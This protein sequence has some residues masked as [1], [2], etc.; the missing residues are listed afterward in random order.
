MVKEIITN[1]FT[2]NVKNKARRVS[3]PLSIWEVSD[4]SNKSNTDHH[5]NIN[6]HITEFALGVIVSTNCFTSSLVS[7]HVLTTC[8]IFDWLKSTF[9]LTCFDWINQFKLVWRLLELLAII[10][11]GIDH[12]T[13]VATVDKSNAIQTKNQLICT[14]TQAIRIFFTVSTALFKGVASD[15]T[16]INIFLT[17]EYNKINHKTKFA[18]FFIIF[19]KFH[20]TLSKFIKLQYTNSFVINFHAN[21]A[22]ITHHQDNIAINI[23][24]IFEKSWRS[25]SCTEFQ[26]AKVFHT[27]K[28]NTTNTNINIFIFFF[29][30][31]R[32]IKFLIILM[33]LVG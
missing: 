21:E 30:N 11:D 6:G 4:D 32:S 8:T 31:I 29:I 22:K 1:Q 27:K 28:H 15:F 7:S 14:K 9:N 18:K 17:I 19:H 10:W 2:H 5:K 25:L 26:A 13:A 16:T 23:R 24:N 12:T 33:I 3:V 20:K